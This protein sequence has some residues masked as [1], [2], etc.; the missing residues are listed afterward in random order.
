MK[1]YKVHLRGVPCGSSAFFVG[2][3][4]PHSGEV[5]TW[6]GALRETDNPAEVTCAKCRRLAGAE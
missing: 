6:Y 4:A 3:R 1:P 2:S 5:R